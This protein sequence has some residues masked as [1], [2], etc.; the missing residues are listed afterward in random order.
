MKTKKTIDK[1]KSSKAICFGAGLVALD[2]IL[3]GNPNT[4]PRFLA[5]G[6]CGNVLAILAYLG[7]KSYPIARLSKKYPT[8]LLLRDLHDSC[9][10]TKFIFKSEDGSTPIIIHRIL[11]DS[12]NK[13]KHRFEFKIPKTNI[14]L[15]SYKP[16]LA[17]KIEQIT[18]SEIIPKVFYFDRVSRATIDLAKHYKTKG[19][20]IF[21]EPSS[22]DNDKHFKECLEVTDILKFSNDR[23]PQFKELYQ[24]RQVP[25]EIETLGANGLL[26]RSFKHKS[27]DW[28]FLPA[29]FV[30]NA[31][32]T[33]GAGDWCSAGIIHMLSNEKSDRLKGLTI[34]VLQ[35]ALEF[36]QFLGAVNCIFYGARGLTYRVKYRELKQ[37]YTTFLKT[38]RIEIRNN[39]LGFVV[40]STPYDF[41]ELYK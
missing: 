8:E 37:V 1:K 7:W 40:G 28:H 22:M 26:F 32:D 24:T 13:P 6:S 25:I 15:P 36:G 18:G 41:S 10:E 31:I 23:L 11:K 35:K 33:A 34:E 5:G 14:W 27:E 3:N 19:S 29:L 16:L 21:F 12:D 2:V 9:V 20:L 30:D 38:K 39:D 17:N 4:Q